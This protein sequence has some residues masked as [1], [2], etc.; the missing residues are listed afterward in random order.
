MLDPS[1][2]APAVPVRQLQAPEA[3]RP[4]RWRRGL[5]ASTALGT[6]A[7]LLAASALP[8][9]LGATSERAMAASLT[10]QALGTQF[11]KEVDFRAIAGVG[12]EASDSPG[13]FT[14]FR[15]AAVQF[16]FSV[17]VPLT[18][19]FGERTYPVAQ[20]HD[21]Q[22]FA[23]EAGTP[24]QAI[25]DGTVLEAGW[26]NDGCGYGVK[27]T[28]RIDG[29]D[30]TSRY[31]HMIGE[32]SSLKVGQSVRVGQHVGNVGATGWAFGAH[33]HFA[34]TVSGK[35][36]DPLPYL[37]KMNRSTRLSQPQGQ[38]GANAR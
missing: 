10:P 4:R 12:A 5:I 19:G 34:L 15:D 9:T 6:V 14:N 22:D 21:A 31:C 25:A 37:T 35:P 28:H 18:D 24:I 13:T 11:G 23:A 2:S 33:L 16:P 30:V 26:A 38:P 3:H 1:G 27:L 36:V 20:F 32:S 17:S 7:V 29:Q 8:V